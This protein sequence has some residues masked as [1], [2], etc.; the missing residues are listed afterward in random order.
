MVRLIPLAIA[1][2]ERTGHP[3]R[4]SGFR[5]VVPAILVIVEAVFYEFG[6]GSGVFLEVRTD[7][8]EI[9]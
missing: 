5:G 1:A 3:I 8:L 6:K 2:I 4:E 9:E 7:H